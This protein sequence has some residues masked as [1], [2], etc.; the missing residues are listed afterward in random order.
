MRSTLRVICFHYLQMHFCR[1]LKTEFKV[2][3]SGRMWSMEKIDLNNIYLVASTSYVT[4]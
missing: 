2:K 1:G 3:K 4:Y